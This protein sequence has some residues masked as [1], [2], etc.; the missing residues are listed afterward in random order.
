MSL[1]WIKVGTKFNN[2]YPTRRSGHVKA[3]EY[4][5]TQRE[6]HVMTEAEIAV[7]WLQAKEH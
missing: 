2:C 5:G 1:Y 4:R 3:Q 6:C 7:I